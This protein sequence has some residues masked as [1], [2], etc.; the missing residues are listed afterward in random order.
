M[1]LRTRQQYQRMISDSHRLIG[2]WVLLDMRQGR[3]PRPK[4]G[5]T[6]T[7]KYGKAHVRNRFKR[8]VREAFRLSNHQFPPNIEVHVRP[9]TKAL[10]ANFK[11][12]LN[13]LNSLIAQNNF[14]IR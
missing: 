7:R 9:R 1:R 14:G 13:E 5:I 3:G 11:D 12:I 8:L 10:E 6:V 2:Q 4:L